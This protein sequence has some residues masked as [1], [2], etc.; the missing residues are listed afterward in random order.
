[1]PSFRTTR[2][3]AHSPTRMFDLVADVEHYPEF[4]PLCEALRVRKRV[5]GGEGEETL[6]AEMSVGYKAIRETFTSKVTLNRPQLRIDVEYVDGPFKYLKNV[7]NFRPDPAG[8]LVDFDISYEFKSLALR[9]LMGAMFERAFARFA[10]AFE[11]RAD[12]VYGREAVEDG[13]PRGA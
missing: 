5:P 4:L 7:W 10:S 8:C 12:V 11:R 3:V 13:R 9:L 6:V 1:M 2:R